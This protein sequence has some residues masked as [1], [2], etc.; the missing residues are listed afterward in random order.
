[1]LVTY[2]AEGAEPEVFK[3]RPRDIKASEAEMIEK[4]AGCSFEEWATKVVAGSAQA[5]R[6]L[7]WSLLRR[8]HPA[9]KWED[10]PDF[11]WSELV[12]ERETKELVMIREAIVKAKQLTE[13]ERADALVELDEE[14]SAREAAGDSPTEAS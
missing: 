10:T 8:S 6:V 9:L 3:F 4:R 12:V 13:E 2:T 1:M 11:A 7:L 5:R 14:I